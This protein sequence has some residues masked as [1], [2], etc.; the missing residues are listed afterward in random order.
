MRT[1][2]KKKPSSS[3]SYRTPWYNQG[4]WTFW[5]AVLGRVKYILVV[6]DVF[7]KWVE[8]FTIRST[9]SPTVEQL[10]VNE[11]ICRFG[12]LTALQWPSCQIVKWSSP[13]C[14]QAI[15]VEQTQTTACHLQGNGQVERFNWTLEAMLSETV[16]EN[17]WDWDAHIPHVLF[18]YWT[19]VHKSPGFAPFH[20]MF[21]R[22]AR[23]LVDL[24]L[25]R[26]D[27]QD[28]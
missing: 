8:A 24:M 10:L 4:H 22:S 5:E 19:A 28:L 15:G 2:P 17:Q 26:R 25:G 7:T 13:M 11:L 16:K 18:V 1:V 12:A 6:T 9:K 27:P 20:L 23:L 14:L 21:G 3:S